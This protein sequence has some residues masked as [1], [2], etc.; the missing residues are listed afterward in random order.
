MHEQARTATQHCNKRPSVATQAEGDN[1]NGDVATI[2]LGRYGVFAGMCKSQ[3]G[4]VSLAVS[5]SSFA[6]ATT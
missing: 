2:P 6:S 1:N 3:V 5:T 4:V